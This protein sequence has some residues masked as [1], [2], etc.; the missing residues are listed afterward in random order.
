[1]G[2]RDERKA[3]MLQWHK[4]VQADKEELGD[5]PRFTVHPLVVTED[6]KRNLFRMCMQSAADR[7]RISKISAR[8]EAYKKAVNRRFAMAR[9]YQDQWKQL[10]GSDALEG[11]I[12]CIYDTKND[13]PSDLPSNACV[14]TR[15][16]IVQSLVSFAL[17]RGD[18]PAYRNRAARED[19]LPVFLQA[20]V[21]SVYGEET[22][23]EN[24]H[25]INASLKES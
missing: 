8:Y 10:G 15:K 9:Y 23:N 19:D 1:M 20:W 11:T 18:I 21:S 5:F 16:D 13:V 14:L 22:L 7:D 6:E 4:L 24:L 12:H 25:F 17:E 2:T 3:A